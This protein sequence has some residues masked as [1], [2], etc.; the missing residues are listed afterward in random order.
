[1]LSCSG[2]IFGSS[3]SVYCTGCTANIRAAGTGS[4]QSIKE[5]VAQCSDRTRVV[6][7]YARCCAMAVAGD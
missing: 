6:A 7:G 3:L 5:A 4:G 2:I 1:M